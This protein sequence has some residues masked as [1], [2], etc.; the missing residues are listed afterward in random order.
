[1]TLAFT[2]LGAI[3]K[4]SS[5]LDERDHPTLL[6]PPERDSTRGLGRPGSRGGQGMLVA[7][8][9]WAQGSQA[10]AVLILCNFSSLTQEP[11][12]WEVSF[13]WCN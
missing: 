10:T 1:M 9:P 2:S 6:P 3:I 8:I 5:P 4:Y 11:V 13:N 7:E 12:W